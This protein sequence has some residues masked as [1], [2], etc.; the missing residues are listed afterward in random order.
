MALTSL[1][2][3]SMAMNLDPEIIVLVFLPPILFV[4]GLE[5][6]WHVFKRLFFQSILLAGPGINKNDDIS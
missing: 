3:I 5:A 4:A 1:K 6:N 2:I